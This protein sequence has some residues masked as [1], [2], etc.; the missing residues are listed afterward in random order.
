MEKLRISRSYACSEYTSNQRWRTPAYSR[1][2][3]HSFTALKVLTAV[4][5][6]V[7]HD[8][9]HGRAIELTLKLRNR[10][11][12]TRLVGC[13]AAKCFDPDRKA[14]LMRANHL[15]D[16]LI[17]L[18]SMILR[19]TLGD[20]DQPFFQLIAVELA[21]VLSVQAART[22]AATEENNSVIPYS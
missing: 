11:S 9:R 22:D 2:P 18:R 16:H 21:I 4:E 14:G 7:H 5:R 10:L 1:H 20:M 12:E 13:I 17:E 15:H 19:V 3:P 8:I 6:R